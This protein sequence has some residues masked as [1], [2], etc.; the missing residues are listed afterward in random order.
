M[1]PSGRL[2]AL[3]LVLAG[4]LS[5]TPAL[6]QSLGR[7]RAMFGGFESRT[8]RFSA[9]LPVEG[10]SQ[11][12]IPAGAMVSLGRLTVDIG[13]YWAATTRTRRG[14]GFRRVTGLTDTQVRVAVVLGRDLLV[15][16]LVANLPTGRDRMDP[17]DFDVLG[18]VSSSFLA[19]PVNA[20]ANGA[21]LT[22][23]LA[24]VMTAGAW[25]VGLAASLRASREFT[26]VVDPVAG[27]L[28]YRAGTEG[29]LRI[30]ADRLVGQGRVAAALTV[31]SFGDD[32]YSGLGAVRGAYQPGVRWIGEAMTTV[33]AAGGT[34]TGTLWGYR[35]SAGD[36]AGVS[37]GN[38]ESLAG[39]TLSGAWPVSVG[40]DLEPGL[41]L[42]YSGVEGGSGLLGGGGLGLRARLRPG[43]SAW[44]GV[45]YDLGYL[46]ARSFDDQGQPEVSR[47]R[48]R[49][50]YLSAFLRISR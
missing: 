2:A 38:A 14:G 23:A 45:R 34:I 39:M 24:G 22:G 21:S 37:L 11:V 25:N 10:I 35:R 36:T 32:S 46:D 7:G 9:P 29:R 43:L 28:T 31:S 16:S 3:V 44:S 5:V 15:A 40:M 26:P 47:T 19:F 6:A 33:P 50:W 13:G 8:Y 17:L 1:T 27:P 18:A 12:A 20:Y 48:I 42:R 4:L 41:E 49:T 30:G